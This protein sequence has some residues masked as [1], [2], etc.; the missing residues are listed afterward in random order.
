[1]YIIILKNGVKINVFDDAIGASITTAKTTGVKIYHNYT[2]DEN[3]LP[4]GEESV[5]IS[6]LDIDDVSLIYRNSIS[7]FSISS[8][9]ILVKNDK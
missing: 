6:A 7:P 1:M 5:L 8:E 3:Y 2:D 9:Q 4:E